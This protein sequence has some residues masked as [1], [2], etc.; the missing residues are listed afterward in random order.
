MYQVV[1]VFKFSHI[2][3]VTLAV[4]RSA[5]ICFLLVILAGI[6][7]PETSAGASYLPRAVNP[8]QWGNTIA[9][10]TLRGSLYTVEKSGTL[11]RT[12]LNTGKWVQLG[13][14]E[15]GN[16]KFLFAD[17]QNLYTIEVDGSLYRVNPANGAWTRVGQAGVWK[18]TIALVTL[19]DGLYTVERSGALYRTAL[20]N[21]QWVQLGKAEFANTRLMFSD[22]PNLYTMEADGS[23]YRVNSAN[24]TWS[25]VGGAGS[26][27]DTMVGTTLGG[28]IYSVERSGALYETN[29][30]TGAWKQ[31]GK[32]EFGNA[33]FLFGT[34]G[35]LYTL[36]AGGLYR[37]DPSNGSWVPVGK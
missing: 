5:T 6:A 9:L 18:D 25:R 37:I 36:E 4:K 26:W 16:T 23:L 14:A 30:A 7:S 2:A 10:T 1:S 11:Y 12:D 13:K 33:Q 8:S 31:I 21:A 28:R 24:G 19:N 15:F 32:G 22:G 27:K 20:S 29:P 17:S 34:D 35:S 3:G